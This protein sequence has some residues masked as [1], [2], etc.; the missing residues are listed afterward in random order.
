MENTQ[1]A[2]SLGCHPLREVR[3][4]ATILRI[5]SGLYSYPLLVRVINQSITGLATGLATAPSRLQYNASYMGAD[6]NRRTRIC[7]MV[8][9]PSHCRRFFRQFF[10]RMSCLIHHPN[11]CNGNTLITSYQHLPMARLILFREGTSDDDESLGFILYWPSASQ[12]LICFI[13]IRHAAATIIAIYLWRH[14]MWRHV[15]A[16]C[17][18]ERISV[19]WCTAAGARGC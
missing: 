15:G 10:T 5:S 11:T 2:H 6:C 3:C 16:G 17:R 12:R 14:V 8:A 18:V 13:Y 4:Y 9:Y 7:L 1:D 19:R